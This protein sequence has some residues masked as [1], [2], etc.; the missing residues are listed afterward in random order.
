MINLR[1]ICNQNLSDLSANHFDN[2]NPTDEN[3]VLLDDSLIM[4][5]IHYQDEID[6]QDEIDIIEFLLGTNFG[7]IYKIISG[8][9]HVLNEI[10]S[11]FE[12]RFDTRLISKNRGRTAELTNFGKELQKIFDYDSYRSTS[13]CI[14]VLNRLDFVSSRPCPYCNIDTIEIINYTDEITDEEK[15]KALLDLDH[16]APRCRFPFLALSFYN[17]VPSCTKCNQSFK[18]Q[19]D[20][21]ITTHIHPYHNAF[22]DYFYF[23]TSVPLIKGMQINSFNMSYKKKQMNGIEFPINSIENLHLIERLET[24]K[25]DI[26]R[27]FNAISRF[28]GGA[29]TANVLARKT[30]TAEYTIEDALLD[31]GVTSNRNDI[32]RKELSK[33]YRDIFLNLS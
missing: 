26:M 15:A 33:V 8:D 12:T 28:N 11:D 17:L 21:R 14:A 7:Q 3:G 30:N 16:F 19:L 29:N 5:L 24:K 9:P 22:D 18:S 6:N 27:F 32:H 4:K 13:S 20:F 2:L 25:E 10:I 1:D 31:F 23:T